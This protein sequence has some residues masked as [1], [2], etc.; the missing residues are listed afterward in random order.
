MTIYT[1][2]SSAFWAGIRAF[3]PIILGVIPFGLVYGVA[4]RAVGLTP[5]QGIGMSV[6][7]VSGAAQLVSLEL[8]KNDAA[9]WIIMLSAGIVNLRFIIY[10]ASLTSY[11]RPY[12]LSWRLFLGYFLTDQPYALSIIYFDEHPDA[13]HKQWYHLGHS[14]ML[15]ISWILSSALGLFVGEFIPSD[16]GFSF[17]IPLMFLGLAVPAIKDWTFLFAGLVAAGVA[18]IA[19]PLPN[20]I[21]LLIALVCGIAVG[22]I[23]GDS[24]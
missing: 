21:G 20:N 14:L 19:S 6:F 4:S 2:K 7:M 12:S 22:L 5:L 15:W 1:T 17:A 10:S 8:L 13:P 23:F 24:E 11:L 16:W 18:L 3:I 9:I